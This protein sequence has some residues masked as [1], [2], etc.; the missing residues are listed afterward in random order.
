MVKIAPHVGVHFTIY[1]D[2]KVDHSLVNMLCC[3]ELTCCT[4]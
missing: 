2:C 1:S 4:F 3:A